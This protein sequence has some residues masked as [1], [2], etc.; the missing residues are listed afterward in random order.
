MSLISHPHSHFTCIQI[1]LPAADPDRVADEIETTIGIDCTSVVHAS[2]KSGIGIEDIL[3]QIVDL[4]PPP[5]GR[6]PDGVL[7]ALVFDSVYD[8]YRGV[9]VYFRVIDG[10]VRKGDKIRFSASKAEHEITEI[11]VLTPNQ[12]EKTGCVCVPTMRRV[13]CLCRLFTFLTNSTQPTSII[14]SPVL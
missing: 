5:T 10:I 3:K 13:V 7:K 14:L 4:V 1:D 9:I 6:T 8:P 12:G 11:G 2:A